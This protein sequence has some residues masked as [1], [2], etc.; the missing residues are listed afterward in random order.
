GRACFVCESDD[1]DP[2]LSATDPHVCGYCSPSVPLDTAH[3]QLIIAHIGSHILHDPAIDRSMEPCGLCGRASPL[4]QIFLKKSS[5]GSGALT[6][7]MKASRCPNLTKR[8]SIGAAT[9]SIDSSPCS[10]APLKC[11]TCSKKD[12]AVW[13]Y[14]MKEHLTR[15]HPEV[16]L[17]KHGHLW[18]LSASEIAGMKGVWRKR[19]ER[20]TRKHKS[21]LT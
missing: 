3:P 1:Q 18:K 17:P 6:I 7:D 20:K 15:H 9:K 10:N 16:S 11:P 21:T 2:A 19:K 5:S 13:R 14:N 12:P 8:F 4:C